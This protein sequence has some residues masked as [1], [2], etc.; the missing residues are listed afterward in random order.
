MR[1]PHRKNIGQMGCWLQLNQPGET[2]DSSIVEQLRQQ[3]TA[4]VVLSICHLRADTRI[5]LAMN[6]LSVNAYP[7]A[8]GG[9]VYVGDPVYSLPTEPDLAN[10]FK[11]ACAAGAEWLMFDLEAAVIDGLPTFPA[12]EAEKP[13]T[14]D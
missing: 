10:V 5:G 9:F 1:R 4:M 6:Q 11:L 7:T 13:C 2:V 12:V 14:S 3:T 8:C